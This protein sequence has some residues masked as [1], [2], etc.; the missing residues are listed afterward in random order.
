MTVLVVAEKP[1]VARDIAQ[2]LGARTRA[3]GYFRGEGYIVTWA[4]GHLVALA[5]PGEMN[6]AWKKWSI[7]DLPLLPPSWPLVVTESTRAQFEVVRRLL[8]ATEV[9]GIVCATDA[10]REGELIFRYIYEAARAKKPV[11]RLWIS[12]LT[13]EAIADGFRKLQDGKAFDRLADAARAR[14]RADWL[15]GMNLSRMYSVLHDDNLSVGRVQTPTLAMLVAR[16][17]EI[18][19]FVPEDYLEVVATFGAQAQTP[20][21]ETEAQPYQGT[22]V[23]P[24]PRKDATRLPPDGKEAEAIV[25]RAKRGLARVESVDRQVRRVP[26]PELYDLTELQRHANRLFGYTAQ[27]TLEIAQRLYERRKLISYPRTDSRHVSRAIESTLPAITEAIAP[28]YR[29]LVAE[30]TG[31]RPLGPRFVDDARVSDHH[32]ILPTEARP[33]ADLGADERAIYDLVCRRL[34]QAWHG[35][36]VYGVTTVLTAV[37]WNG[38]KGSLHQ[39]G[40]EHRERRMEGARARAR[41]DRGDASRGAHRRPAATCRRRE[42]RSAKDESAAALHRRHA[43]HGDGNGRAYARREGALEGDARVRSRHAGD[44]RG[45]PRDA[46]PARVRDPR[47]QAA[48]GDRQGCLPRLH[49]ARARE[50]PGDDR[51]VG[52]Q[53]RAHRARRGRPRSVHEG[54]RALR[55]R[56]HRQRRVVPDPDLDPARDLD[57]AARPRPRSPFVPCVP[58]IS[59]SSSAPRSAFRLSGP[60]K[61]TCVARR[62]AART[63]SS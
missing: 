32:A 31:K 3:D 53:A 33:P 6:P 4:I 7:D 20:P 39:L 16:E 17:L 41:V 54:H 44:A 47:R 35:E 43:A 49:G 21:Q 19:A 15:V 18:R 58:P 27:R 34:L 45:D 42:G 36:H 37:T 62:P 57:P 10:G 8:V 38:E 2:V 51:R 52:G 46:A 61:R 63:C 22:W 40:N 1:S 12:S 11:R 48:P 29:G 23:R 14:S 9:R 5:E 59:T 30:G 56:G 25:N 24:G 13:P 28:A 26:P 60:I 55:A 50:E